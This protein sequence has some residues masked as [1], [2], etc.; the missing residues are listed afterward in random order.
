MF[1]VFLRVWCEIWHVNSYIAIKCLPVHG[2]VCMFFPYIVLLG[3][4]KVSE[5]ILGD[6]ADI[7]WFIWCFIISISF[8]S[9]SSCKRWTKQAIT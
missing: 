5:S 3:L 7:I 9:E 8:D 4:N 1:K 6:R 2:N